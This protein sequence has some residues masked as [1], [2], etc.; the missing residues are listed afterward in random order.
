MSRLHHLFF[1]LAFAY[2]P[3]EFYRGLLWAA[4]KLMLMSP[5]LQLILAGTP[6]EPANNVLAYFSVPPRHSPFV[7][8]LL[9]Q[10]LQLRVHDL[11]HRPPRPLPHLRGTLSPADY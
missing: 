6:W 5:F 10:A 8:L 3:P 2:K 9:L 7:D 1:D 11:R 4:D